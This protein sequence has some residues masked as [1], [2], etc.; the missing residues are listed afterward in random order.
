MDTTDQFERIFTL[1]SRIIK[2][3]WFAFTGSIL[4]YLVLV[5]IV[6][7]NLNNIGPA[8]VH[9]IF[10]QLLYLVALVIA[11][12]S[13]IVKK[14][15][16]SEKAIFNQLKED[17][18]PEDVATK[19]RAKKYSQE[20]LSLLRKLPEKELKLLGLTKWYVVR[21]VIVMSLYDIITLLGLVLSFVNNQALSII[22]FVTVSLL[23]CF[24]MYGKFDK[25]I[26]GG[27]A[28]LENPTRFN[29]V[30][31]RES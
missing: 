2:I 24:T 23:L 5:Y 4:I 13:F 8:A 3:L 30:D 28:I 22:P 17:L 15:V 10:K 7:I 29:R 21:F 31:Y 18:R 6:Q 11:L 20:E 19:N 9:S 16:F 14:I 1:R 27:K 25:V 12:S 26:E